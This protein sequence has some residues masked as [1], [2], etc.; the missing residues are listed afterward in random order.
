MRLHPQDRVDEYT[1]AGWWGHDTWDELLDR[2][3]GERPG[4]LAVVDPL[5]RADLTDGPRRELTWADLN[6]FVDQLAEV[7]LE[8]GVERGDVVGVQLPNSVE[9]TAMYLAITRIGAVISPLPVQYR[10]YELAQLG[11]LANFRTFV[12]CA[13][14]AGHRLVDSAATAAGDLPS[15]RGVLA[16]GDNLPAGVVGLDA[17]LAEP[18]DGTALAER[19]ASLTPDP[20][21]ALTICWTSGTESTPKGIPRGANEWYISGIGSVSGAALTGDDVLLN[22]FPMVNMA[23]IAGMLVPWLLTGATL[24]QHHPFDAAT[25]FKQVVHHQVTYTVAPP[26]VLVRALASD[27]AAAGV[28][29]SLRVIGSGSAPLSHQMISEYKDRFGID[30]INCFGSNEGTTLVGDP[31]TIPDPVLRAVL[32]PR[33]GS[34][35]HTWDNEASRGMRTKLVDL[36]TEEEITV[37]G[38]TG[39]LRLDG[40]SVFAGYLAGTASGDPFDKDG[41]FCTGDLFEYIEAEPGDLRYLRYVDR[42]KDL[43][44][45]GGMN[46]SPAEIESLILGCPGV[47]E[48]AVIGVPDLAMGERVCAVVVPSGDAEPSLVDIVAHL[49]GQKIAAFKLPESVFVVSELPRNPVGKIT[50]SDLRTLTMEAK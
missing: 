38:H 49:R 28:L 33:F 40:P 26:A 3:V 41:Y 24:V 27:A 5:N 19:R 10:E 12:T 2:H 7:L 14:M 44:V 20:N 48:A 39:E 34:P 1:A 42:A 16:F 43:I 47:L 21:V 9:L 6:E 11:A 30:I 4:A 15:L 13:R 25:F 37:A 31:D 46:I 18:F 17:R 29:D 8:Q 35:S 50:K 45:R 22:P 32:F 36:A 23:G